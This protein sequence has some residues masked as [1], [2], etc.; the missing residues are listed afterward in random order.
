MRDHA[1]HPARSLIDMQHPI[2]LNHDSAARLH[3]ITQ[4]IP[5]RRIEMRRIQ[6]Q[7]PQDTPDH[8]KNSIWNIPN[9]QRRKFRIRRVGCIWRSIR[10]WILNIPVQTPQRPFPRLDNVASPLPHQRGRYPSIAFA[11]LKLCGR[12][13]HRIYAFSIC[14]HPLPIS[15]S[16][17]PRIHR[18]HEPCTAHPYG[19]PNPDS[20][21]NHGSGP[22]LTPP[23]QAVCF[24][25]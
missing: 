25:H 22:E 2:G 19:L 18:I 10:R 21:K 3:Q 5:L 20:K 17:F 13:V 14:P 1:I 24:T 9:R 23:V 16:I 12:K 4:W 8:R 15:T 7:I 11:G 6:P